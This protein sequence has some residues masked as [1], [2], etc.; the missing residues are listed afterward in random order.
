MLSF[1]ANYLKKSA[2]PDTNTWQL[3]LEILMNITD[4]ITHVCVSYVVSNIQQLRVKHQC[5]VSGEY[6]IQSMLE[7][8][9]LHYVGIRIIPC[10]I[11]LKMADHSVNH[12][13][14]ESNQIRKLPSLLNVCLVE[15]LVIWTITNISTRL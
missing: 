5:C 9:T 11:M 4:G 1:R 6:L 15:I 3:L 14:Y 8:Y 7:K 13:K 12:I 2:S 10:R